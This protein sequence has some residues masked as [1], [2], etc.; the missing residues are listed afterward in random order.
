MDLKFRRNLP[1]LL[2]FGAILTFLVLGLGDQPII[3]YTIE[4]DEEQSNGMVVTE[5][6]L[7]AALVSP[8]A[9]EN[10]GSIASE[11]DTA[12]SLQSDPVSGT[13]ADTAQ[14]YEIAV[15]PE[16]ANGSVYEP[17]GR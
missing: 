4:K 12:E 9:S 15:D 3:A 10:A 5:D 6:D 14:D 11:D 13:E 16:G 2:I 1:L 17:D 8:S 7:M